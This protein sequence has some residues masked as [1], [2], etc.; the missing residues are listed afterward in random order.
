MIIL[1]PPFRSA[2]K[3]DAPVLAELINYAGEGIPLYLWEKMAEPGQSA[4]DVGIQRAAREEG[5]FS[6]RNSIIIEHDDTAAGCLIDYAIPDDVEP[7]PDDIPAMF[8]PLQELENQVAGS[9]YVYVLA[10]RPQFRRM[11]MG[12]ALLGVAERQAEA[13]GKKLMSIIVSDGNPGAQ[14]LYESCGYAPLAARS[15]VKDDWV[16]D[17]ENWVLMTKDL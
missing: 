7:I 4:M 8:R 5:S 6:Y 14:R 3:D 11:G 1:P 16:N 17:G 13:A 10:V 9:W 2:A 12:K 15:M